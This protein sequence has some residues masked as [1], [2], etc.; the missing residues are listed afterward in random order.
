S[1]AL[2]PLK[3]ATGLM[4]A[5]AITATMAR[6]GAP[7]APSAPPA[8]DQGRPRPKVEAPSPL[9]PDATA[10]AARPPSDPTTALPARVST[11][12]PGTLLM[13]NWNEWAKFVKDSLDKVLKARF[14]ATRG[15]AL[16]TVRD[17]RARG[18]DLFAKEWVPDDP[19]SHGGDGLG[20]V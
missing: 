2:A 18:A 16:R 17:E 14:D 13:A 8:P 15:R 20:P 4:L 19:G 11:A 7:S 6:V 12:M 10:L 3:I 5:V 1:M 9:N